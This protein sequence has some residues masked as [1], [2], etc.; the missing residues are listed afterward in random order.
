[1]ATEYLVPIPY[2][3]IQ[4]AVDAIPNNLS[5][6]GIHEIIIDKGT[7][8][9]DVDI[10]SNINGDATNYIHLKCKSGDEHKGIFGSGVVMEGTFQVRLTD[11][12]RVSD[13]EV[14]NTGTGAPSNFNNCNSTIVERCIGRV[15]G[16]TGGSVR[17]WSCQNGGDVV[18]RNCMAW[19]DGQADAGWLR[20][21]SGDVECYGC[22]SVGDFDTSTFAYLQVIENCAAFNKNGSPSQID[23]RINTT[24]ATIPTGQSNN[25][26][27]DASATGGLINQTLVDYDFV[28]EPNGDLHINIDSVLIDQ[29]KDLSAEFTVDVDFQSISLPYPIGFDYFVL[30]TCWK[31]T[32]PYKNSNRLFTANGPDDFP[33]TLSVPKNVDVSRGIMIDE[34]ELIDPSRFNIEQ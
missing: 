15:V 31:Y 6:T 13:I 7:Y 28:N 16:A 34:G 8:T 3:T 20:S 10:I 17:I 21:S 27:S 30:I 14:K 9:E 22:V 2:A 25:A 5:G 4:D 26:S 19:T 32:A 18:F 29:G 23:I 12:T 11:F 24:G 1:M 33:A